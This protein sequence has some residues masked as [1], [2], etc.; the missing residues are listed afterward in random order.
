MARSY[1]ITT[2]IDIGSSSIKILS[3]ERKNGSSILNIVGLGERRSPGI[4]R[5][6]IVDHEEILRNLRETLRSVEKASGSPVKHAYVAL[7][8]I[9][10]NSLKSRS[11]VLVVSKADEEVTEYDLK[12]A[13]AKS[14]ENMQ[15]MANRK[16]LH[17]IPLLFKLD[18]AQVLGKPIGM[19]GTKLEAEMLFVTGLSQHIGDI[20]KVV[21]S[22]GVAVDDIIASPIASALPVTTKPERE[23][24]CAVIN[25]GAGTVSL[26]VFEEGRLI[27]LE[28]FP[29]GSMHIT[30][31]IAL[32]MQVPLEDA[33][34]LKTEY[35][36][37]SGESSK[38][39]L[40]DIIEARLNDIFEL[41]ESHLKKINR[42]G[43]LPAG[44]VLTG[45][46]SRLL[47]LHEVVKDNLR[48]PARVGV[49]CSGRDFPFTITSQS[50][51][52]RDQV[53]NNPEWTTALGLC[54]SASAE[55]FYGTSAAFGGKVRNILSKIF[56]SLIP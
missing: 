13:V 50:N 43:L 11:G 12:R 44:I 37:G 24:G 20:V 38:R 10:L 30:N 56:E 5:G 41:V 47:N 14:E 42:N 15:N 1:N 32:G 46:G 40:S 55:D 9:G 36:S 48:L 2:G 23:V 25:I 16:I 27:S 7:S 22:A 4:R 26:A 54:M 31:D 34:R 21:E 19:R 8:G 28:V 29:I 45:G 49:V 39:K 52:L 18:G 3:A 35:G 17:A 6:Y 51:S 33:E 53:L